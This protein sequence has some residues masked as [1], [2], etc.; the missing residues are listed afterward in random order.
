MTV[1]FVDDP[2]CAG[3]RDRRGRRADAAWAQ[4][5]IEQPACR[6]RAASG[7]STRWRSPSARRPR[8]GDRRDDP[9]LRHAGRRP[10]PWPGIPAPAGRGS[11]MTIAVEL[12]TRIAGPRPMCSRPWSTS[13]DTRHGSSPR[14]SRSQLL[15]GGRLPQVR[16]SASRRRSRP[17]DGPR[18]HVTV[19]APG[20]GLRP[21]RQGPEGIS[22]EIDTVLAHDEHGHKTALVVAR[23]ACRCATV[24]SNRWSPPRRATPPPSTSRRSAAGWRWRTGG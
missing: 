24:C 10:R 6:V 13:S 22:I 15:D 12:E 11:P 16:G 4:N 19:L 9:A 14:A 20:R 18:R 5:L 1:G 2:A 21:A 8:P 3:R 17:L 7:S 23:S